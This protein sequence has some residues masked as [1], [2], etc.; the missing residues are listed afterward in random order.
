MQGKR[1]GGA[2]CCNSGT[3]PPFLFPR[4]PKLTFPQETTRALA[5]VSCLAPTKVYHSWLCVKSARFGILPSGAGG[6][7]GV[8]DKRAITVCVND[9]KEGGGGNERERERQTDIGSD[10]KYYPVWIICP[11]QRKRDF[12]WVTKRIGIPTLAFRQ[13]T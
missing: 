13:L 3:W 12:S 8:V 11:Q 6:G 4:T 9:G 10:Q 7:E 2:A 5:S 1:R